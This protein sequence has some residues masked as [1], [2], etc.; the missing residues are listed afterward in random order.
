MEEV[1]LL[2]ER[3]EA[4]IHRFRVV[5][6]LRD[7]RGVASSHMYL[8]AE[9][10]AKD[11]IRITSFVERAC[12]RVMRDVRLRRHLERRF[13]GTFLELRFEDMAGDEDFEATAQQL[14]QFVFGRDPPPEVRAWVRTLLQGDQGGSGRASSRRG[15][16]ESRGS[17][18]WGR[19]GSR[20]R[21]SGPPRDV[22]HASPR[23]S[24]SVVYGWKTSRFEPYIR[25]TEEVCK[26]LIRYLDLDFEFPPPT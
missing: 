16:L 24:S 1:A 2:L 12:P 20:R 9:P 5:H 10:Y 25:Y 19:W 11:P 23:N 22:Y 14:H 8:P 7:P 13:P 18:G 15:S 3:N 6:L 26:D 17:S 21:R 4:C